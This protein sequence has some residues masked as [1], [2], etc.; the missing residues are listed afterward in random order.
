MPGVHGTGPY[1][2]GPEGTKGMNAKQ[3]I[4]NSLLLW[5]RYMS[6]LTALPNVVVTSMLF[7]DLARMALK[8]PDSIF[9]PYNINAHI[10]LNHSALPPLLHDS[11]VESWRL[12]FSSV[13]AWSRQVYGGATIHLTHTFE[14]PKSDFKTG[15]CLRPHMLRPSYAHQLNIEIRKVQPFFDNCN[16]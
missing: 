9:R 10:P 15:L 6:P 12:N 14:I 7:W 4:S 2:H 3:W 8:D 11:T 13:L 5:K 16:L 1:H